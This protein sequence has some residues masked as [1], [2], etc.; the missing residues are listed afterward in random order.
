MVVG[1]DLMGAIP[2]GAAAEWIAQTGGSYLHAA[3]TRPPA[4]AFGV[5]ADLGQIVL[6]AD[7]AKRD[8][9]ARYSLPWTAGISWSNSV[10]VTDFPAES[11]DQSL[12]LAQR[13]LGAKGGVVFFPAGVFYFRDSIR[14]RDG[15]VLR[16]VDS[17]IPDARSDAYRPQTCFEFPR[18]RPTFE[19]RG[20]PIDSAFKGIVLDSPKA[21][22]CGILDI[23]V[24]RGHV[25]FASAEGNAT[26]RNRF[27]VGCTFSNAAVADP[28]IPDRTIP[29]HPWQRF[30]AR[31]HPAVRVAAFENVLVANNR[32]PKS[33]DDSFTM[34]DY[35]VRDAAI[36]EVV[37]DYDNRP[38][39]YVND[40]TLGGPGGD[41]PDGNP[42]T[43]PAGFRKG[44]VIRDNYVFCTGRCA[45]A[46]SGDGTICSNNV[47][48]FEDN[49]YR[50]TVTGTSVSKGSSTNDNRAVQMRGWRWTVENNDYEVYRNICHDRVY[51][52]N[53]GE[54][55]MHE[56]HANCTVFDSRLINNRGNSYLSIF[57]TGGINGLVVRGND[58]RTPG[59][60]SAIYVV[61][62]K[63][64]GRYQC[65]NVTIEDNTTAGSGIEIGGSPASGNVVR[66]NRHSGPGGRLI[67]R[68]DAAVEGNTGYEPASK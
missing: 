42:D 34:K 1:A 52:I 18:Y 27:V 43:H 57:K 53:D 23:A 64:S 68:A 13:A 7:L 46:F 11:I 31:H 62:D 14:L 22:N 33:G 55:L 40:A 66:N 10:N 36:S 65:R 59:G 21:S 32:I 26:G 24:N 19:G 9:L 50:P 4:I 54:G 12:E 2:L 48:R 3:Y 63:N 17:A 25:D 29:Q 6:P 39:I 35:I 5:V 45:I 61:A 30:T 58:I 60:I 44:L 41:G 51:R 49:I 15:I 67:N 47:I 37:F 38:G 56:D 16:G 28:A 8:P 20:T